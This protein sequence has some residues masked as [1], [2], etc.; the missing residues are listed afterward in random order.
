HVVR[1]PA[2]DDAGL[3]QA[4]QRLEVAQ[5]IIA[6]LGHQRSRVEIEP[7]RLDVDRHAESGTLPDGFLAHEVRVRDARSRLPNR[8]R[9]GHLFIGI[10]QGMDGAIADGVSGELQPGL[11]R[12][13]HDREQ[14]LGRDEAQATIFRVVDCVDFAH[15][16]RLAHVGTAGEHA[17][18]EIGLDA[19]DTQHR[20]TAAQGMFGYFADR[21]LY[22]LGGPVRADAVRDRQAERQLVVIEQFLVAVDGRWGGL[23][24]DDAGQTYRVVVLEEL[25]QAFG[26]VGFGGSPAAGLRFDV[27]RAAAEDAGRL[28]GFGVLLRMAGPAIGYL[29]VLIDAAPVQ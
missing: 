8:H 10:Q 25:Q 16:P 5:P 2:G 9:P 26:T 3:E 20:P 13:P 23:P 21:L 29:E 6:E 27:A 15:A 17:A 28:A 14:L 1:A 19:D 24:V 4:L 22:L 11:D 18:V 12:R 7:G